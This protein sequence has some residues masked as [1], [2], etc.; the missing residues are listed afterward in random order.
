MHAQ[1][2][3]EEGLF[4]L[5]DVI[6]GVNE[7]MLRRHPH[8]F[9]EESIRY[10]PPAYI[11]HMQE[12]LTAQ[13]TQ[14]MQAVRDNHDINSLQDPQDMEQENKT[15]KDQMH[16]KNATAY[17]PDRP[18]GPCSARDGVSGSE[19]THSPEYPAK[20]AEEAQESPL[21]LLADWKEIKKYEKEG[22]EWE[23]DYL[24]RAFDEAEE[25]IGVAR[26]R[27]MEKKY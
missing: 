10:M 20:A 6:R 5:E 26:K 15:G 24:F 1:M 19:G 17:S 13:E 7:K 2:A 12:K 8:V 21:V 23:E 14:N 4:T 25:L 9:G 22:R 16:S 3:E 18:E 27:K 11:R